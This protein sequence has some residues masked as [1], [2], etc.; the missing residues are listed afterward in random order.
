MTLETAHIVIIRRFAGTIVPPD[1][2]PGASEAPVAEMVAAVVESWPAEQAIAFRTG[3]ELA[4]QFSLSLFGLPIETVPESLFAELVAA[5]ASAPEW[6]EFWRGLR[7]LICLN[8]YALPQA[9]LPL[10]M[11]GPSIDLGGIPI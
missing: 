3:L 11:P 8:F 7:S 2:D 5:I 9:Y 10:G 6:A 4:D 1:E